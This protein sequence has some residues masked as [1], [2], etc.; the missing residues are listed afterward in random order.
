MSMY[1]I[2][3][4]A[5]VMALAL[6]WTGVM[7]GQEG[8]GGGS[9]PISIS[10]TSLSFAATVGGAAPPV[11]T[12]SV[13]AAAPRRFSIS[14]SAQ[15]GGVNWLS[16]SPTGRQTA[17]QTITVFVTPGSLAAGSYSGSIRVSSGEGSTTT[18]PVSLTVAS[19]TLPPTSLSFSG[20][21]SGPAPVS[22]TLA[23]TGPT[24][25]SFKASASVQNGSSNWLSISPSGNPLTRTSRSRYG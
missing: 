20:T 19:L 25:A 8:G 24:A 12:L 21:V 14:A 23:V 11:Q 17:N 5:H 1:K 10:V 4:T 16:V 18:V 7:L 22:Q 2:G 6:L 9:N 3:S 15:S 13:T